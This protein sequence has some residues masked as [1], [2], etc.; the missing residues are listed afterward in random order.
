MQT[1]LFSC[2]GN[3]RF[4]TIVPNFHEYYLFISSRKEPSFHA[5]KPEA[6]DTDATTQR[7]TTASP[8]SQDEV[9][10]LWNVL[11]F[12]RNL[13]SVCIR[14]VVCYVLKIV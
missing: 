2:Y 3:A 7:S 11:V 9:R 8:D 14:T 6:A 12:I 13:T 4:V 1:R 5:Y 10:L